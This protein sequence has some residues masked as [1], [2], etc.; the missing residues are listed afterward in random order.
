MTTDHEAIKNWTKKHNGVPGVIEE[1]T[2]ANDSRPLAII[3]PENRKE[4][5]YREISWDTFFDHFELRQLALEFDGQ[6]M[7]KDHRF[8]SR[9]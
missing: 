4:A 3:W 7:S 8:V 2:T 1:A 6:G 9:G 5:K